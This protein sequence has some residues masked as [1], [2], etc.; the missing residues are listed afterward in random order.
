MARET[1]KNKTKGNKTVLKR[2]KVSR[3]KRRM[4]QYT[5]EDLKNA[6]REIRENKMKIREASRRFNVP[7][8]TI[9]D[10]IKGRVPDLLRKPG[11][12]PLLTVKGEEKI[13]NWIINLAKCGFPITKQMLLDTVSKIHKDC[14]LS[15]FKD[16]VPKQ[17]WYLNFLK[18][19][20]EISLREA[21]GINK[22]RSAVTEHSVRKWFDDL[23]Q[24]LEDHNLS[25]IMEDPKRVFNG[26]ESGFALCPSSGKVLGPKGFRNFLQVKQGNEKENITVLIMFNAEG[27]FAPPLVLF[28][29]VR[30]PRAVIDN[31]PSGWVLGKSERG[32]MT[33]DVFFEFISNDFNKWLITENIP[34]PVILFVD[35]HKSH[36][37]MA[38]S[39]WC[40]NN[41]IILYAL[42]PNTTHMLQPADVSVFKP[43]KSEWK[44]TV[45]KWQN[46]PENL[47]CSVTKINFCSVFDE[48]LSKSDRFK[49]SVKNGFRKSGLFPL[50]PD[51]VDFSKCVADTAVKLQKRKS[52]EN[53][54]LRDI[55]SAKKIISK[56]SDNLVSYGINVDVIFTEINSL[57]TSTPRTSLNR[58]KSSTHSISGNQSNI[59]TELATPSTS[60]APFTITDVPMGVTH[61]AD[62]L[63]EPEIHQISTT[64][65]DTIIFDPN[66]IDENV[67]ENVEIIHIE[68]QNSRNHLNNCSFDNNNLDIDSVQVEN[69]MTSSFLNNLEKDLPILNIS[70]IPTV[71][72]KAATIGDVYEMEID[73]NNEKYDNDESNSNDKDKKNDR[74][75]YNKVHTSH[76]FEQETN[77]KGNN[78]NNSFNENEPKKQTDQ[79]KTNEVRLQLTDKIDNKENKRN[80]GNDKLAAPEKINK[81]TDAFANHLMYPEPIKRSKNTNRAKNEKT[82]KTPSAISSDKWR[83]Y[84]QKKDKEKELKKMEIEKRKDERKKI[85]E[86]KEEKKLRKKYKQTRTNSKE[87]LKTKGKIPCDLC[88]EILNSDTEDEDNKNIGCD[89]C[90]KWFHKRCTEFYD[91]PYSIAAAKDYKCDMCEV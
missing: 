91:V 15:L 30:P 68:S 65:L 2:P 63:K 17:T 62:V 8:A 38:I 7:R 89:F 54:S 41:E 56:I 36:L 76:D 83:E 18:R 73:N 58:S 48:I 40:H 55:T 85:K 39:E 4:Y 47:N 11:P 77:E 28:P 51:A 59:S 45:C 57:E 16:G 50:N 22:A 19:N 24:Y 43:M 9:Q 35:G 29:Y 12:P 3:T 66:F 27:K 61:N 87:N 13:K 67:S 42:P 64:N 5:E 44:K 37:T 34:R 80:E 25:Y 71:S 6:L 52:S 86:S 33:S 70:D 23:K 1:R 79:K 53:I 78:S 88:K 49:N 74:D 20:P 69:F 60:T 46:K 84:Y 31:M 10:R 21:E 82:V 26:D 90:D 75:K 14:G 81:L 72:T 32:W